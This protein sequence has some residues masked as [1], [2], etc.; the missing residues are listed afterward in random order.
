MKAISQEYS[1]VN[2]HSSQLSA[3]LCPQASTGGDTSEMPENSLWTKQEGSKEAPYQTF[4]PQRKIQLYCIYE[5]FFAKEESI[6][7]TFWNCS[8]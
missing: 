4:F 3:P 2:T 5:V 8:S 7:N 6:P 1:L